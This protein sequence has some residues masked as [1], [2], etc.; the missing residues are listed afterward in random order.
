MKAV[1]T[2]GTAI[3]ITVIAWLDGKYLADW[4]TR[5][6]YLALWLLDAF[7]VTLNRWL[8]IPAWLWAGALLNVGAWWLLLYIVAAIGTRIGNAKHEKLDAA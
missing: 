2:F 8:S 7:G 6:G 5:P 3:A 4:L 1:W